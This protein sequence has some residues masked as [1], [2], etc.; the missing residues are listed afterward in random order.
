MQALEEKDD[1]VATTIISAYELFKGADISSRPE[2]NLTK[3]QN[4]LSNIDVLNLTLYA[5]QEAS[6]IYNEMRKAGCLIGEF[7]VLIAAIAKTAGE[8]IL[9]RD[10]HFKSVKGLKLVNW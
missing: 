5:C 1:R 8:G 4:L 10:K 7:D 6:G 2:R 9:T 3:I